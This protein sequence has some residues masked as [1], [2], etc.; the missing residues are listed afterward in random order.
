M[1]QQR[2][3]N[4]EQHQKLRGH[5]PP[6]FAAAGDDDDDDDDDEIEEVQSTVQYPLATHTYPIKR[7][8]RFFFRTKLHFVGGGRR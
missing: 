8:S 3:T 1:Q 4:D 6:L 7:W 2:I 5:M